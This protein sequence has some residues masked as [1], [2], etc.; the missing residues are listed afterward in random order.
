MG[1]QFKLNLQVPELVLTFVLVEIAVRKS[2]IRSGFLRVNDKNDVERLMQAYLSNQDLFGGTG[3]AELRSWLE[4]KLN[5]K[6]E[7]LERKLAQARDFIAKNSFKV[8]SSDE[9]GK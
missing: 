3:E 1:R 7:S 4:A 8:D 9:W 6:T 2:G 5:K